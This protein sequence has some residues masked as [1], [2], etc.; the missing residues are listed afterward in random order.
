VVRDTGFRTKAQR[1]R[2]GNEVVCRARK[3]VAFRRR[4]YFAKSSDRFAVGVRRSKRA[5]SIAASLAPVRRSRDADVRA[6][7][8]RPRAPLRSGCV[9]HAG[10]VDRIP[11]GRSSSTIG[12][13]PCST[14]LRR[15]G[16]S[17]KKAS[18]P[19][20]EVK[21]GPGGGGGSTGP[22]RRQMSYG[23]LPWTSGGAEVSRRLPARAAALSVFHSGPPSL[24]TSNWSCSSAG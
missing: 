14:F 19:A 13:S 24:R 21:P 16:R 1:W 2:R 20:D 12:V 8:Q 3:L 17:G 9:G 15:R 5:M 7:P 6:P 23:L 18:A 10:T 22:R 4:N 11:V